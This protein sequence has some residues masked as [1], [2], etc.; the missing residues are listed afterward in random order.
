METPDEKKRPKLDK[1]K[2]QLR[3][4]LKRLDKRPESA[5]ELPQNLSTILSELR[6][7]KPL[8]EIE[9]GIDRHNASTAR[10]SLY[11]DIMALAKEKGISI[12]LTPDQKENLAAVGVQIPPDVVIPLTWLETFA[13]GISYYAGMLSAA[14]SNTDS[15]AKILLDNV[16]TEAQ[17]T[18]VAV[19]EV[20]AAR[21]DQLMSLSELPN[22]SMEFEVDSES[23]SE[24]LEVIRAGKSS[25]QI[26][27]TFELN[28]QT[29]VIVRLTR[30]DGTEA[31]YAL[32]LDILRRLL[33]DWQMQNQPAEYLGVL[34]S[35]RDAI[36]G[37][38]RDQVQFWFVTPEIARQIMT[39]LP[40]DQCVLPIAS[41][42]MNDQ[43]P[44]AHDG[45]VVQLIAAGV[46]EAAGYQKRMK[47]VDELKDDFNGLLRDLLDKNSEY[48]DSRIEL[49]YNDI[50]SYGTLLFDAQTPDGI[51]TQVRNIET[52]LREAEQSFQSETGVLAV[53]QPILNALSASVA[54]IANLLPKLLF[55]EFWLGNQDAFVEKYY[56][57]PKTTA[58]QVLE[59]SQTKVNFFGRPADAA[60]ALKKGLKEAIEGGKDK[61]TESNRPH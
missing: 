54:F 38:T 19:S 52:V 22:T 32:N 36:Q 43:A 30:D 35:I 3:F 47:D 37:K 2:S 7:L 39:G 12:P 50:K 27:S 15:N 10:T 16:A 46:E 58:S 60:A 34:Q 57:T 44:T 53:F 4:L 24:F 61:I 56:Q 42:I 33:A 21:D 17:S 25:Q 6:K 31:T 28:G 40:P 41:G 9:N 20:T 49:L 51:D 45:T 11:V 26:L 48:N 8:S 13:F 14:V 55:P 18:T 5:D 23:A 59:S 1:L 29:D